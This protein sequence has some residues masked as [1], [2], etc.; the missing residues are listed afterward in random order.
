MWDLYPDLY[1]NLN[2][3]FL[4]L[5]NVY[6]E[7]YFANKQTC[8]ENVSMWTERQTDKINFGNDILETLQNVIMCT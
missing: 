3:D 1:I 2:I 4:G 8:R 7:N 6:F 5:D